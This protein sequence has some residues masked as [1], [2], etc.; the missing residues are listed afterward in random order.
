LSIGVLP[1][2]LVGLSQ[3]SVHSSLSL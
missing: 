1:G 2:W 3:G